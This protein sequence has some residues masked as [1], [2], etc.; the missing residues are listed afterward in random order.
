[1]SSHQGGY[2]VSV[3]KK[4]GGEGGV[5]NK[6]MIWGWECGGGG[7]GVGWSEYVLGDL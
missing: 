6:K 5:I 3:I 2:P 1:M 4:G 7:G